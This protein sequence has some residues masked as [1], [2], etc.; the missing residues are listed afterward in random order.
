MF[1]VYISSMFVQMFCMT[2]ISAGIEQC[3]VLSYSD[4]LRGGEM[5]HIFQCLKHNNLQGNGYSFVGNVRGLM[6]FVRIYLYIYYW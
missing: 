2:V 4:H 6:P 3:F 1:C 5:K